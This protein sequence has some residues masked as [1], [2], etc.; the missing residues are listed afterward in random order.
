MLPSATGEKG[1]PNPSS[2]LTVGVR[3]VAEHSLRVRGQQKMPLEGHTEA[4]GLQVAYPWWK[5]SFTCNQ[6][7]VKLLLVGL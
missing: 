4:H 2:H 6:N 5:G 7:F 3:Y 1:A